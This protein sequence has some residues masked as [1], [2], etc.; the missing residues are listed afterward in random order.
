MA[1]KTLGEIEI[2]RLKGIIHALKC[3]DKKMRKVLSFPD[4]RFGIDKFLIS[5]TSLKGP[6]NRSPIVLDK[7][8]ADVSTTE[9]EILTT[10]INT[11]V[12][13]EEQITVTEAAL[14][15]RLIAF[16]KPT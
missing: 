1:A 12:K 16:E 14:V 5:S 2:T 9:L 13:L 3:D 8:L 15:E 6:R 11:I 10:L 7:A 4:E